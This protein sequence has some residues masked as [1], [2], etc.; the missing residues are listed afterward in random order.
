MRR[1]DEQI[2]KLF[3]A[4]RALQS[5]PEMPFGFDTRTVALA[6]AATSRNGSARLLERVAA[7]A[8]IVTIAAA[9]GTWWQISASDSAVS[10]AYTIADS[11]IE[12]ALE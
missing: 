1:A 3:R 11:A 6:R 2:V 7:V 12:G 10:N 9:A 4:A 8:M 5:E